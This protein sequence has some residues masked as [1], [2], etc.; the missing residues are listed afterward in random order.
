[1]DP[2]ARDLDVDTVA[3][4]V[5]D[6]VLRHDG[7]APVR[8]R[9]LEPDVRWT[10]PGASEDPRRSPG[11]LN[12]L[13][14]VALLE[15]VNALDLRR[16]VVVAAARDARHEH[17][18]G[19][20]HAASIPLVRA[21]PARYRDRMFLVEVWVEARLQHRRLVTRGELSIGGADADDIRIPNTVPAQ[22]QVELRATY[23]TFTLNGPIE[24]SGRSY[25]HG[26][27]MFAMPVTFT[28]AGHTVSLRDVRPPLFEASYHPISP[29][30]AALVDAIVTGDTASRMIYADWLEGRG[31]LERANIVRRLAEGDAPDQELLVALAPTN[32]RWRARVLEPTIEQCKR[33]DCPKHWGAL[34]RTAR[35]DLRRCDRCLKLAL[36][37]VNG[38]QA[39]EHRKAG[40]VVVFDPFAPRT[41]L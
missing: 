4:H 18:Q 10:R 11:D 32:V 31:D 22:V 9:E 25:K 2:P 19:N 5:G 34:E 26:E 28:I 27:R 1:M 24:H 36:Y 12:E 23:A 17:D 21:G 13:A 14:T 8:E 33:G 37:C 38:G 39:A 3:E 16:A 41:L 7:D 29:E 20:P 40:G 35:A 6:V 30:E 15:P